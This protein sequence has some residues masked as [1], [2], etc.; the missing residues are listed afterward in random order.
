MATPYTGDPLIVKDGV[1]R[2]VTAGAAKSRGDVEAFANDIGVWL[3][4]TANGA[5][6][7]VQVRGVASL[8]KNTST[9]FVQGA[10]LYWDATPGEL[11]TTA[12]GNTPAGIAHEAAATAAATG[13]VELIP[14]GV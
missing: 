2:T 7:A 11:T 9:A 12:S 10:K 1:T 13:L 6:G 14:G 4:A 3:E 5:T 8:P